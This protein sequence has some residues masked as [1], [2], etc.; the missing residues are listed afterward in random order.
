MDRAE[1]ASFTLRTAT[2]ATGNAD[3][4]A[5]LVFVDANLVAILVQLDAAYYGEAAGKWHL[6]VGFGLCAGAPEPFP[7]LSGGLSW[8]ASRLGMAAARD[9]IGRRPPAAR[10]PMV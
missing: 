4:N 5:V 9:V 1:A 10:W 2:V 8:I 3:E 7:D 6:E